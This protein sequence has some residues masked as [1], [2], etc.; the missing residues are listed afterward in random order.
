LND[1]GW[2]RLS[3]GLFWLAV[4]LLTAAWLEA[5]IAPT[6]TLFRQ[7]PNGYNEGWNAYWAYTA[8]HGG[9]LYPPLDGPISNNYPPLSFYVAGALG[10]LLG[11]DIFAGRLLALVSLMVIAVSLG[12]WLRASGSS[13]SG[14][15]F[16][17]TLFLAAFVHFA[18]SYIGSDDP[19][20]MAHAL[21]V[22][23]ATV[24]W[25]HDFSRR[26]VLAGSLL[27]VL[28]GL[29][30]HLLI[31]LPLAATVW[32][33]AYRRQRLAGW[34]LVSV[35]A[36]AIAIA[37]IWLSFGAVFFH[38]MA[39]SRLYSRLLMEAG[40]RYVWQGFGVLLI[41]GLGALLPYVSRLS[42]KSLRERCAFC[43][44]YLLFAGAIGILAA[45]GKG[46]YK[47]AF[48]DLLIADVI[49]VATAVEFV[50]TRPVSANQPAVY[51]AAIGLC[52]VICGG[53]FALQGVARW[54]SELRTI[55]QAD[56]NEAETIR[57]IQTIR[58]L[59]HGAAACEQ[60]SL[61]Y[62][63]G[64]DFKVDFFNY[65]QKL[66]TKAL[67]ASDCE[68]VFSPHSVPLIQ[69]ESPAGDPRLSTRLPPDC[70]AT[71]ARTYS[72]VAR[73]SYGTLLRPASEAAGRDCRALKDRSVAHSTAGCRL[74]FVAA[75]ARTGAGSTSACS[76]TT[77][78][79]PVA[80]C[81]AWRANSQ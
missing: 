25:R 37:L 54:P 20:L 32:I 79:M 38:D 2:G 53:F 30:K 48:F 3:A 75:D 41:L 65:G 13:R 47:N 4:G 58:A 24:L 74:G 28:G 15:L 45:G 60:L 36:I 46:V 40:A 63:A 55:Q 62:W 23:G 10:H 18:P 81:S 69:A 9:Q 76:P 59:G 7:I 56:A 52:A 33:A 77:V 68:R 27:M 71:I 78:G 39:S 31:P 64:S 57:V 50:R 11:D 67:P 14:A 73:Y 26:A 12:L 44:I 1:R 6:F 8:W 22:T 29:I 49:A 21:M 35:T 34:L 16:G 42:T 51:P 61:C 43:L 66:A 5:F 17:A 70:N 72:P 80:A 19:Q